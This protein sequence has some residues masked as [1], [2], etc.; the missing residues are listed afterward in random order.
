MKQSTPSASKTDEEAAQEP[1]SRCPAVRQ[2]QPGVPACSESHLAVLVAPN[3]FV[4]LKSYCGV[5]K[6]VLWQMAHVLPRSLPAGGCRRAGKSP[7]RDS[8]SSTSAGKGALLLP[9]RA[10][11]CASHPSPCLLR[12]AAFPASHEAAEDKVRSLL[13]ALQSSQETRRHSLQP[14]LPN[15]E[16]TQGLREP[17]QQDT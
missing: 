14:S 11:Q 13:P 9:G 15:T 2:E 5:T 17:G 8:S 16:M 7:G 1:S 12:A 6:A 10:L 4:S 3:V